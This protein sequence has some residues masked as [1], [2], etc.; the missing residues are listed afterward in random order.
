MRRPDD[1]E[2]EDGW[3]IDEILRERGYPEEIIS[4]MRARRAAKLAAS[5]S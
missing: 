4:Q 1:E 2:R 5:T 3:T